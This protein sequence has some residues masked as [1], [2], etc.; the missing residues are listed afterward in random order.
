MVDKILIS[1]SFSFYSRIESVKK[2]LEEMGFEVIT[3]SGYGEEPPKYRTQDLSDEEYVMVK[4]GLYKQDDEKISRADELLIL[5]YNKPNHPNYIGG[6]V[7]REMVVGD[8]QKKKIYLL[9][10]IP[11]GILYDE[12]RGFAPIIINGD[13][14]KIK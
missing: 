11:K 8:Q 4:Q 1:T 2:S 3:P 13:L 5:N 10:P 12:I 9:N 7:F 14:T 6:A